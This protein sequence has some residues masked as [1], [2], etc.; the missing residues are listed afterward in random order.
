MNK[1]QKHIL[2]AEDDTFLVDMMRK[3]LSKHDVRVSSAFNGK[4]A[5]NLLDT[6]PPDLLLL[7]LLMPHVDG[8][9]V[10][11]HRKDKKSRFPVVVCSN[12]SDKVN[13]DKCKE[14]GVK[15]YLIKSDMDDEQLW[16]ILEKYLR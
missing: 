10:L 3:V 14:F 11:Q 8:Y 1:R 2:V 12:L 5:I 6:D 7:D 4:E 9:A 15:E 13:R 16:P